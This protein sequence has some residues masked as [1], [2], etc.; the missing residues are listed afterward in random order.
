MT[1]KSATLG[2]V[3]FLRILWQWKRN[4]HRCDQT[5]YNGVNIARMCVL[6]KKVSSLSRNAECGEEHRRYRTIRSR[7][8][9]ANRSSDVWHALPK[10]M[11][12]CQLGC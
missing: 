1:L 6:W 3:C 11:Y 10:V 12:L 8:L 4:S 5:V 9:S 7:V 2:S